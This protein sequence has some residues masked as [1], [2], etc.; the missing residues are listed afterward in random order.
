M[1]DTLHLLEEIQLMRAVDRLQHQGGKKTETLQM[2]A[3]ETVGDI[4]R[5]QHRADAYFECKL[6]VLDPECVQAY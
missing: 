2:R 6:M 3:A 1:Q 4:C 5:I